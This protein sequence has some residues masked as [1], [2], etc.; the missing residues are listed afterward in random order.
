MKDSGFL[1]PH[2]LFRKC[3]LGDKM[4]R[5][6]SSVQRRFLTLAPR[7]APCFHLFVALPEQSEEPHLNLFFDRALAM[8][9]RDLGSTTPNAHIDE[10]KR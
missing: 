5:L 7:K 1:E 4:Q 10:R 6:E 8:S 9:Q 2:S 3:F